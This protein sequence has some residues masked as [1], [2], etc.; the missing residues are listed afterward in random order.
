M[1]RL[2]NLLF[3]AFI[4]NYLAQTE[5][6]HS[7]Y[8]Y[9]RL[10]FFESLPNDSNEIIFLGNSITDGSEWSEIFNDLRI[11]NR[12][13]S[14]DITEGVFDR[15]DEVIEA[16]P[17]KIFIMIGVNDLAF[18]VAFDTIVTNYKKIID[19]ISLFS[20]R[21]KLFIQSVLPVNPNFEKFKDHI[22]K[23]D[24][25]IQLNKELKNISKSYNLTYIDLHSQFVNEDDFLDTNYT[26]DGLH[27]LGKG[28][29]LWKAIVEKF[30]YE[31]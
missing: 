31:K 22:N 23:T 9:Q 17:E 26:N 4:I 5:I 8:Y 27:L 1:I 3:F 24:E 15:L 13:I 10:S 6:K 12:G 7:T 11:K 25:I 18:G 2:I 20:P 28:Y 29:M 14:G 19:K 21:T 16:K 30:I